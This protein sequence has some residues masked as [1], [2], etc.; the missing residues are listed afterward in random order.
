M[1]T[2]IFVIALLFMSY[3]Y[4]EASNLPPGRLTV[5]TATNNAVRN[6]RN[7]RRVTYDIELVNISYD[8]AEDMFWSTN[9]PFTFVDIVNRDIRNMQIRA[10]RAFLEENLEAQRETL[11][12]VITNHFANI[13]SAERELYILQAEISVLQRELN[14][15]NLSYELGMGSYFAVRQ[16]T[17]NLNIQTHNREVLQNTINQ[18]FIEL[19]R[20]MGVGSSLRHRVVLDEEFTPLV[21]RNINSIIGTHYRY[22]IN[23]RNARRRL[24]IAEEE[25]NNHHVLSYQINPLTGNFA[26]GQTTR[27][28]REIAVLNAQ[29]ELA[30]IIEDNGHRIL[31][32]YTNIQAIELNIQ[33]LYLQKELAQMSI[34]LLEEQFAAGQII[35]LDIYRANLNLLRLEEGLERL[36]NTHYILVMQFNNPYILS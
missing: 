6:S 33:G 4:V 24:E 35:M 20:I 27:R 13:I 23:I 11:R 15:L 8:R 29:T 17:H 12:F 5:E 19:N 30:Q 26:A 1:K 14:I 32:L 7:I 9:T 16:A 2:F 36:K 31:D 34:Y 10:N 25:F 3:V 21:V 28:E 18:N 22:N